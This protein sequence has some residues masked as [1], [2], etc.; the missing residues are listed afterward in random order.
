MKNT[1]LFLLLISLISCS[2]EKVQSEINDQSAANKNIV[3]QYF[4]HFNA[5]NWE[6]MAALYTEQPEMKDP[7]YGIEN[8]RMTRAEIIEK[9]TELEKLIPDVQDR[10]LKIYHSGKNLTVEFESS[11][12]GPD[13]K[14]FRLPICTIFEIENGKITKDL[15]YYDNF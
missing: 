4:K 10:V 1:A 2:Q 15:T 5:H 14:K 6:Q 9:Y 13:G 12:T 3:E 8:V 11:G 7:A